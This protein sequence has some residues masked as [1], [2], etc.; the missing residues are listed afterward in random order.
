MED[1]FGVGVVEALGERDERGQRLRQRHRAARHAGAER[2]A[3]RQ[4]HHQVEPAPLG[5]LVEPHHA[6]DGG[7]AQ[8]RE[9]L[10][11]AHEP[12]PRVRLGRGLH[13]LQG[14]HHAPGQRGM[15]PVDRAHS[16]LAQGSF[17]DPIADP[18]PGPQHN[19]MIGRTAPVWGR[20]EAVG[21]G[22]V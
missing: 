15:D 8:G 4:L 21:A 20:A 19:S 17:D 6:H 5:V 1:A 2:L 14:G 13:D 18:V 22:P 16:S 9:S 12:G 3:D 7:V 11:L 10:G